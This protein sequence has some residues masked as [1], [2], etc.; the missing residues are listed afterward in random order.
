[1][2]LGLAGVP[3]GKETVPRRCASPYRAVGLAAGGEDGQSG[4]L[5]NSQ[6]VGG[7][8]AGGHPE[9]RCRDRDGESGD[10]SGGIPAP[11]EAARIARES[12]EYAR[13]MADDHPRRFGVFAM[14]PMPHV[15]E[16]LKEIAHALATLG[17]IFPI[18]RRRRQWRGWRLGFKAKH[19]WRSGGRMRRGYCRILPG[20]KQA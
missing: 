17:R 14:L 8:V 9:R 12:N 7:A 11:P 13:R 6:V 1:V 5:A 10:A 15:D 2:G 18:A 19:C 16:S 4:Y 20:V 3:E